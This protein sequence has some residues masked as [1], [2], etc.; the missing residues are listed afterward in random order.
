MHV[1]HVGDVLPSPAVSAHP[2]NQ[3]SSPGIT[4]PGLVPLPTPT[5]PIPGILFFC[6]GNMPYCRM[7]PSAESS[8][9]RPLACAELCGLP[10]AWHVHAATCS[11]VLRGPVSFYF[12]SFLDGRLPRRRFACFRGRA[13]P[14]PNLGRVNKGYTPVG[15]Q[16]ALC[17]GALVYARALPI[18]GARFQGAR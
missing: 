2:A 18:D 12:I 13:A 11:V 10:D 5:F 15:A 16:G 6:H 4:V 3:A 17:S 9:D 7:R 1:H 14:S 8:T